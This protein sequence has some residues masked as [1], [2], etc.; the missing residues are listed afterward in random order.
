M[1]NQ[2]NV[3][4]SDKQ[5]AYRFVVSRATIWRW[6]KEGKFPKPVKLSPGCTRWKLSD[7]EQWEAAR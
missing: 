3:Y 7:V 2:S 5:V 4:Q 6:V 1:Q